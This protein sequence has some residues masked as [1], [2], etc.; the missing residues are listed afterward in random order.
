MDKFLSFERAL[1]GSRRSYIRVTLSYAERLFDVNKINYLVDKNKDS[2]EMLIDELQYH[3]GEY[4][5]EKYISENND[6]PKIYF[7]NHPLGGADIVAALRIL[8]GSKIPF[9]ILANHAIS[10][11]SCLH[12][13]VVSVDPTGRDKLLNRRNLA[14]LVRGFGVDYQNLFVFPAGI[15]SRFS[16]SRMTVTDPTWYDTFLRIGL[17]AKADFVPVWFGGQN[18]KDFYT[19]CL[20]AGRYGGMTLASQF[21]R[22]KQ[23]PLICR[24]GLPIPAENIS[25]FGDQAMDGLRAAVY[26]LKQGIEQPSPRLPSTP[27]IFQSRTSVPISVGAYSA[28]EVDRASVMAL[29]RDCFGDDSWSECDDA[30]LHLVAY[31]HDEPIGYYRILRWSGFNGN[32][33]KRISPVHAVFE[34][35]WNPPRH[36]RIFEFGRFCISPRANGAR[37]ARSLWRGLRS[38]VTTESGPAFA[39]G[40]ISLE[41]CNPVL[42]SAM[43]SYARHL[44]E[45]H[46]ADQFVAR[47]PLVH[48]CQHHD[49]RPDKLGHIHN[50]NL[51]LGG[52]PSIV[53]TYL[54]LG[55]RFGTA[56]CWRNFGSRPSVLTSVTLQDLRSGI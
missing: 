42:A 30:A 20:V 46:I 27:A 24:I 1:S 52:L 18:S 45:S 21:F 6:K 14:N 19:F 37:V 22:R 13:E 33:L 10:A 5:I 4:K 8:G 48:E 56:A 29:R 2:Y 15:C 3:C 49:F 23:S 16:L 41:N 47:V 25:I 38:V 44:S 36:L 53:R 40:V 43:F 9:R 54:A 31:S 34:V 50:S 17:R 26:S 11:P 12:K 51:G 28:G 7:S 55:A 32:D 35:K 39:L